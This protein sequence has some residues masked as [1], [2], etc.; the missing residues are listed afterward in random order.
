MTKKKEKA[1]LTVS[2][3]QLQ[4]NQTI[5]DTLE[6]VRKNIRLTNDRIDLLEK[7][8]ERV[9]SRLGLE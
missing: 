2:D 8:L 6:Q 3:T 7:R 4:V 1:P 9:F 5:L